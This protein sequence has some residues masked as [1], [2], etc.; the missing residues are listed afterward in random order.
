TGNRMGL[1]C[2]S[3][4]DMSSTFS[5]PVTSAGGENIEYLPPQSPRIPSQESSRRR[6]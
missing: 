4:K 3:Q 6:G 2:S 1:S 5:N